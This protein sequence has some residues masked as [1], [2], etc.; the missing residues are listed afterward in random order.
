MLSVNVIYVSKDERIKVVAAVR[1]DERWVKC[2]SIPGTR[3]F[4]QF[5]PTSDNTALRTTINSTY[6]DDPGENINNKS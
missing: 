1:L 2:K 4:H 3:K 5:Q 6:Q